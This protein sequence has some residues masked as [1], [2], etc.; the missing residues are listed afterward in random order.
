MADGLRRAAPI[1]VVVAAIGLVW[2]AAAIALN[3][4]AAHAVAG[5]NAPAAAVARAAWSLDRPLLPAP[6]QVVQTLAADVFSEPVTS[7]R[8]LVYHAAVTAETAALGFVLALVLGVA[9]AVA[10]VQTR[11]LDRSL[12]PWV[13]ASQTIP[14]LA[15]APMVVVVLGNIGLTG[16]LPKALIAGWLSFFPITTAMVTGLRAP[17]RIA[18]DLLRTYD[19]SRRDVFVKLRWPAALGFLF[20]G[21]KVAATLAL[22][23]AIVAELP[24]GAQA[25]LGAR[26]LAGSYYGQTLQIWA[27]LAMAALLTL[28]AVG[29]ADTAQRV[30]VARRGGRL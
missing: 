23:G 9:L 11:V 1:V 27:A 26:L 3:G 19:A 5:P 20:A 15:I 25:G 29:A 12:M 8:S 2:Y 18:V 4:T 21:V 13:I 24:T 7:P 6:H 22:V 30:L 16:V 10:I 28:L 14:V 17:D